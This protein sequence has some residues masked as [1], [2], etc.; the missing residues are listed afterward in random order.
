MTNAEVVA[1]IRQRAERDGLRTTWSAP[2]NRDAVSVLLWDPRDPGMTAVVSM[3]GL[4]LVQN[5]TI[6]SAG[7][8]VSS[9][10]ENAAAVLR[11]F[12]SGQAGERG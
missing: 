8:L 1:D 4:E 2:A 5:S 6:Q 10:Y 11:R 7:S 9:R 3:S 12:N